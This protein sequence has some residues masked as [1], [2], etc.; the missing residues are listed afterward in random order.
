MTDSWCYTFL[1]FSIIHVFVLK[2]PQVLLDRSVNCL[3]IQ[4][5]VHKFGRI[6]LINIKPRFVDIMRSIWQDWLQ[7]KNFCLKVYSLRT[8]IYNS[9]QSIVYQK[10]FV[11]GELMLWFVKYNILTLIRVSISTK[12]KLNAIVCLTIPAKPNQF[13]STGIKRKH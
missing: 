1:D 6:C 13:K 8:T 4:W 5:S 7:P 3:V 11:W 10:P 12:K 2:W 9:N